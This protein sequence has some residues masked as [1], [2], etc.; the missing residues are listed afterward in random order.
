M[1]RID[2][3]FV[4][5]RC[6]VGKGKWDT[7]P[8]LGFPLCVHTLTRNKFFVSSVGCEPVS[9]TSNTYEF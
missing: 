6:K 5:F 4:L 2:F 7:Y 1:K 8:M 3:S 9:V